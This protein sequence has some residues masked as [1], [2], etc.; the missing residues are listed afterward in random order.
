MGT[1]TWLYWSHS[2]SNQPSNLSHATCITR[3]HMC[4]FKLRSKR[5]DDAFFD[6][7]KWNWIQSS[8]FGVSDER[9]SEKGIR[10]RRARFFLLQIKYS[11]L[12]ALY[13][14]RRPWT[15]CRYSICVSALSRTM[16]RRRR[17]KWYWSDHFAE[18]E[19]SAAIA[20]WVCAA[21]CSTFPISPSNNQH[22]GWR[23]RWQR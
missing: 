3:C 23:W 1:Q 18:R 11:F 6:A 20:F 21:N 7:K 8:L 15:D 5:R 10:L 14:L 2:H 17:K 12:F 4:R 13:A 16:W 19:C 22:L 9:W